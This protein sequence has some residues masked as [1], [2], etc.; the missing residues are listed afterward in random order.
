MSSGYEANLEL[1]IN[2]HTT[3]ERAVGVPFAAGI[4]SNFDNVPATMDFSSSVC[5]V[6]SNKSGMNPLQPYLTGAG[7]R[8]EGSGFAIKIGGKIF[9]CT[10]HHVV[11]ASRKVSISLPRYGAQKFPCRIIADSP[12]R[13]LT[14]LRISGKCAVEIECVEFADSDQVKDGTAV[15]AVGYPLGQNGQKITSGGKAGSQVMHGIEYMQTDAPLCPGN[16]GGPAMVEEEGKW[17]VVGVNNAIIPGQNSVGYCIPSNIVQIFLQDFLY[18]FKH[19]TPDA[20]KQTILIN[21]PV[22]GLGLQRMDQDL[23]GF[24]GHEKFGTTGFYVNNVVE[25]SVMDEHLQVED[26]ILAIDDQALTPFGEVHVSWNSVG[27]V[28]FSSV[29]GRLRLGQTAKF[30]IARAGEEIVVD[31]PFQQADP[32]VVRPIYFPYEQPKSAVVAGAVL[33]ELNLNLVQLFSRINPALGKYAKVEEQC[34]SPCVVVTHILEGGLVGSKAMVMPSMVLRE[35]NGKRITNLKQVAKACKQESSYYKFNFHDNLHVIVSNKELQEDEKYIQESFGPML[36]KTPVLSFVTYD[37][38]DC[39]CAHVGCHT[40]GGEGKADNADKKKKKKQDENATVAKKFAATTDKTAQLRRLLN[41]TT[42][43]VAKPPR[44]VPVSK[45]Q[46]K[47]TESALE[48][49]CNDIDSD[50]LVPA[51]CDDDPETNDLVAEL[52]CVADGPMDEYDLAQL[53]RSLPGA[54]L[55]EMHLV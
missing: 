30:K 26:Q 47:T 39:A 49:F 42:L 27:P 28:A 55:A 12:E 36:R 34:N 38:T 43:N 16:S 13:D 21:K 14:L 40:C 52:K 24:M 33:Q 48:A 17:K 45:I 8:S 19:S 11:A 20:K 29:L 37:G 31:V 7:G 51:C 25:G 9:F 2:L 35:I 23:C 32:R 6:H 50:E 46:P 1:P 4:T 22:L 5:Q 18:T 44:H 53:R 3:T 54:M 41:N 10:N 15:I